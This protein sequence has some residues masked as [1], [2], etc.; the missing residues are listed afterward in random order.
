M[1]LA[2]LKIRTR[3]VLGFA[4]MA[5]LIALLGATTLFGLSS[6]HAAFTDVMGDR[7]PKM[8]VAS[9]IKAVNNEV[10]QAIRNLFIM[11]DPDDLQ[12]Q[13]ELIAASSKRTSDNIERLAQTLTDDA[14]RAALDQLQ[15]ARAAYRK[16]RD[17]VIELL[18]AG[19]SEEAKIVLLLELR[20]V[21]ATYM[22]RLDDLI[23]LQDARMTQAGSDATAATARTRI[24]V[25]SLLALAGMLAVV[26]AAAIIRSITRPIAA[27]VE[28]ARGVSAG[29]LAMEFQA[30]G[31]TETGLLLGA[32]HEMKTRLGHIVGNVRS[33][34]E[35]VASASS[36]IAQ[37]NSDL[38]SRTEQQAAALE[39]TAASMEQ[40]GATVRQNADNARQAD[41]LARGAAIVA[42][43]GG[44]VVGQV[45]QTMKGINDSSKQVAEIIGV[46]DGIAFQTNIL[47]LNAA[48][49]AARAGAQGRGFAVVAAE[50]RSLAQRSAEAA[51]E[52]KTLIA[53]SV[54][55]VEQ[56]S[57]LV[58]RAGVTMQEV[59]GSI[60]R[61]T[62]IVAE[63]SAAS[64]EQSSGV[65]QV[66]QA[67]TQM[68][69]ATQ[70]NAALVQQSAAAAASLKAQAH[71][72][73]DA[74]AVFKLANSPAVAGRAVPS[75]RPTQPAPVARAAT[76]PQP[77]VLGHVAIER[78][79]PL[80]ARNVV[81]P[82][83]GKPAAAAVAATVPVAPATAP[84]GASDDWESF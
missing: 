48:V 40:L 33:N 44:E 82:K 30:D 64:T 76:A 18:K 26:L 72:L 8:R 66:G 61:V 29:D 36:Q 24:V 75:A 22:A 84:R 17:R 69:Q 83:F 6:V 56:G 62:D 37:G 41:Q 52:I 20:P 31:T 10:S 21:Q 78:R 65:A 7:Y 70:Q 11:S 51:K 68:D 42:V 46:I 28:I 73:V 49:E 58:D 32:L 5:A 13:Y 54:E 79:S 2:S 74:V 4:A 55:R 71:Q 19:R 67:V 3:L 60:R 9:E 39:Q 45:V 43:Q 27:A 12:A 38:S 25:T 14:G 80:R 35:G 57:A 47:A 16:P 59:V 34:A 77:S 1:K 81:R 53:A 23:A 50:V 15:Q 63:I